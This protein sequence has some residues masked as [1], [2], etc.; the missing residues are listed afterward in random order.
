ML[1][2]AGSTSD[3][4]GLNQRFKLTTTALFVKC[5]PYGLDLRLH[6]RMNHH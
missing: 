3:P 6:I 2:C 4:I 1:R 5:R